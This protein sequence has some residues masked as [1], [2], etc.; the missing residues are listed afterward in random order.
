MLWKIYFQLLSQVFF[1]PQ[2]IKNKHITTQTIEKNL[3]IIVKKRSYNLKWI[4]REREGE[5][6]ISDAADPKLDHPK[7]HNWSPSHQRTQSALLTQPCCQYSCC[8]HQDFGHNFAGPLHTPPPS[9]SWVAVCLVVSVVPLELQLER[10]RERERG[11]FGLGLWSNCREGVKYLD[12][13]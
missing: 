3:R 5:I 7:P 8:H 2:Q 1:A 12:W 9:T 6:R 10:E 11:G 13:K 4:M